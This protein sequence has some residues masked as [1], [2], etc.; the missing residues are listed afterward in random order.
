[1]RALFRDE[2]SVAIDSIWYEYRVNIPKDLVLEG[3]RVRLES[4][5][6][7]HLPALMARCSDPALW[8]F[9][10]Q[11]NPLANDADARAYLASALADPTGRPFAIVDRTTGL[12]IGSTRYLDIVPEYR[13]LEIGWTFL[14]RDVWRTGVNHQVK[15][16]LLDY[17]FET[18]G[19]IR[20]QLKADASNMRSREAIARIGA[21]YEGTLRN[22]RVRP[23]GEPR[24]ISYFSILE[25]EWPDVRAELQRSANRKPTS[26]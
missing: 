19:A 1:M 18:Y 17:A 5:A 25:S 21:T 9:T 8:E 4:L 12:A 26:V 13:K 2:R 24:G 16:L 20:V 7:R 23:D 15:L 14:T 6:E 3:A 11:G 22:C 10:F